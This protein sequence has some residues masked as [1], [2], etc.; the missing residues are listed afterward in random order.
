M[1]LNSLVQECKEDSDRF[2]PSFNRAN[3][4]WGLVKHHTIGLAGEVGEFANLIKKI[5]RGSLNFAA[6]REELG[7]ELVD[8]LIYLCDLAA[9]LNVD[10]E[11]E[12]AAKREFNERR[13]IDAGSVHPS[14]G[15]V[16]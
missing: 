3:G 14:S 8:V 6:T 4:T 5:D 7:S 16:Q 12:Y 15:A 13:F 1:D 2:F 11:K 10:L 9:I